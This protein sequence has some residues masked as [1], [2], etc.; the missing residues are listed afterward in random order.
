VTDRDQG[1]RNHGTSRV[2]NSD[3]LVT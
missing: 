3:I 2:G 1:L